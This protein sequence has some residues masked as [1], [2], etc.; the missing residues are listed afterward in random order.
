MRNKS[1]FSISL[2]LALLLSCKP[3][4]GGE[5]AVPGEALVT[6]T[7]LSPVIEENWWHSA[8]CYE[9][10]VRSF[11]D[12]DGDGI[13][14]LPGVV[15]KLDYLNDGNPDTSTDLGVNCVWLMPVFPATSY[16]GYDVLDYYDINPEYGSLE[17]F[18]SLLNEAHQRG[19]KII[20]DFV[21]N[22]TSSEHPWFIEAQNNKSPYHEYY[23]WSETD[24]GYRGPDGQ[25]VWH[26]ANNGEYYYGLFDSS[27]PDLNIQNPAVTEEIYTITRFWL[28]E[29]GVDGFRIDGA[30]HLIEEGQIQEN[31]QSTH[32]WYKRFKHYYEGINPD[33]LMLGEVWDTSGNLLP[34]VRGDELDMVFNFNLASAMMSAASERSSFLLDYT[35]TE[36]YPNFSRGM[37]MA[38]FLTNHDMN[39]AMNSFTGIAEKAYTAATLL[40][41]LPG[42]PFIY[43]GEE[44]GMTG[45][46]PDI[47]IRTPMQWTADENA[48]F[49]LGVP[50]ADVNEDY[51]SVN[52]ATQNEE[53]D[54]LL[55]F[56]RFLI[57]L[58]GEYAAL[59]SGS[60][61]QLRSPDTKTFAFIRY[62]EGA[63]ILVILN[64]SNKELL[65]YEF[66]LPSSDFSGNVELESIYAFSNPR[67]LEFDKKGGLAGYVPFDIIPAN[68]IFIAR[69]F[70]DS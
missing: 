8:V 30:R 50:W 61:V 7:V 33:A 11:Y 47:S 46:K 5:L 53:S 45:Q 9:L 36:D 65:D 14:D 59:K 56:Y 35:L 25:Q 67:R 58:R 26:K 39:R 22:H 18:R 29:I 44:I 15:E 34:Y 41:T 3:I 24:P 49:S 16:H 2:L 40:L 57:R 20:I 12:S 10:F 28:Q 52:V 23:V 42:T 21:L 19:I 55:N 37:T 69:F 70:Y 60:F 51:H 64:L 68:G 4:Q 13:G 17:D 32:D 38:T 54:S 63:G 1:I 31:T 27:M 43:Y 66:S 6:S 62:S 48:G